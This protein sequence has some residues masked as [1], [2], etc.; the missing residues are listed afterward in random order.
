MFL[1]PKREHIFPRNAVSYRVN[2]RVKTARPRCPFNSPIFALL[3]RICVSAFV[4]FG[5]LS[6]STG[7]SGYPEGVRIR[8]LLYAIRP[9]TRKLL[10][11]VQV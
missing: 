8:K 4:T 2:Y 3:S 9:A 5:S 11:P 1:S 7:I 6:S 10:D